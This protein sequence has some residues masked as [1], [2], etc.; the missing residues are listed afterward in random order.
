MIKICKTLSNE[1]YN[2]TLPK[3]IDGWILFEKNT[4]R[5]ME[6]KSEGKVIK[7]LNM[8]Y[9]IYKK[10]NE[11]ILVFRGTDDVLDYV[12]DAHFVVKR[13]PP[14]MKKAISIYQRI[15]S[16]NKSAKIYITGHSLGGAYAQV[17]TGKA[18][19][20][21][22]E[23]CYS[24]TFNAPG[25]GYYFKNKIKEKFQDKF[26]KNINN[27][28]VMNDFIGN[29]REHL[30]SSYYIQ[31]YPLNIPI[32][33]ET[34]DCYTPHNCIIASNDSCLNDY[35]SCPQGW[36]SKLAW[37]IFVFDEVKVDGFIGVFKKALDIKVNRHHLK[38]AVDLIKELQA[39][40]KIKLAN[41]FK[42]KAGKVKLE[43]I[44]N[45]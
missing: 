34:D 44:A 24:I 2:D 15:R 7:K 6:L 14:S 10:D 31:P 8:A 38:K 45:I 28:I 9:A 27:Y 11:I 3:D 30:G 42:F 43:L 13:R 39:E 40:N 12:T 41:P 5:N 26:L 33:E 35:I 29:F 22:D 16:K 36:N 1:V 20:Q 19:E 21:G 4:I 25:L 37:S 32:C 18:I 23:N 17:V